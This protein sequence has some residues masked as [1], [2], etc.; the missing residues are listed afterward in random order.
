MR[1]FKIER[2]RDVRVTPRSFEP[3]EEA[4]LERDLRRGWD[5]IADQP[6]VE[7]LLKFSA[8]VADRVAETVWHPL[9]RLEKAD[10]GTLLWRSTV[11]GIIEIRLWILSWG[12]DVEV[13]QPSDLRSQVREIH[14]R[15]LANYG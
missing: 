10:D 6:P 12:D 15:A 1:T 4:S 11:S 9:Q 2:I 14:E 8:N 5:I 13:L 3:P 7:I